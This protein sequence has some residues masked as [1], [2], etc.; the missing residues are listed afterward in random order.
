M[1]YLKETYISTCKNV[2]GRWPHDPNAAPLIEHVKCW[3]IKFVGADNCYIMLV[4]VEL[5]QNKE[6]EQ[7]EKNS[8]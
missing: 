7:R 4:A 6:S 8:L 1:A 5:N 2:L 3:Q